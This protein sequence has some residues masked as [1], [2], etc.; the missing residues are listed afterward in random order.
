MQVT[1]DTLDERAHDSVRGK[2]SFNN[3][4]NLQRYMPNS[5]N[6]RRILRVNL[7][8]D[9]LQYVKEFSEFA[10]NNFYSVLSFGF[11]VDQGRAKGNKSV[12]DFDDIDDW[13]MCLDTIREIKKNTERLKGNLVIERKNCYPKTGCDLVNQKKPSMAIRIDPE[14]YV[15]PCLYFRDMNHSL[16]NINKS[17]LSDILNGQP[18]L[19]LINS[20]LYRESH[21]NKCK[22]CIWDKQCFKGCPALAYSK[23]G[24]FDRE[25]SCSFMKDSFEKAVRSKAK[26]DM[27]NNV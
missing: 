22:G 13:K 16:G 21:V 14:G 7:S 25:I 2:G 9:N 11:L 26:F 24:S 3:I 12:L 23:Y 6:K 15:F 4:K 27:A 10:L 18:F 5:Y 8:R 17:S 1:I 20:I 19:N